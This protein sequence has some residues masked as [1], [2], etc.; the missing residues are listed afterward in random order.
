[1]NGW[2]FQLDSEYPFPFH[3]HPPTYTETKPSLFIGSARCLFQEDYGNIIEL[4]YWEW[5][6]WDCS[7]SY[8]DLVK[9]LYF[10][11]TTE[12]G[13]RVYNNWDC[14]I[15]YWDLVKFLYFGDTTER[16][17]R[18]YNTEKLQ[19]FILRFSKISLLCRYHWKRAQ[20]LQYWDCS[21]SYWDLVKFLYFADTTESEGI[22]GERRPKDRVTFWISL[23]CS[24]S[25][26]LTLWGM[27]LPWTCWVLFQL[28]WPLLKKM[29][30]SETICIWVGILLLFV[31]LGSRY[32]KISKSKHLW[33][34]E[35]EK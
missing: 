34:H 3:P 21:I 6:Y 35:F 9:F 7:I 25:F 11:D 24:F 31:T 10:A 4:L 2:I 20:S 12:R 28:S 18:V 23:I 29:T 19:H 32:L 5:Q 30:T 33:F 22:G 16:G 8:W 1:M 17:L 13:L 26:G 15:S 27:L 14:S